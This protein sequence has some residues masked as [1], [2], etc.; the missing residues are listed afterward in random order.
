MSKL[1]WGFIFTVL[2]YS[3]PIAVPCEAAETLMDLSGRWSYAPDADN[4]LNETEAREK[5]R[6]SGT[7][8]MPVPS[9][10]SRQDPAL[11]NYNGVVW[12]GRPFTAK[13]PAGNDRVFL[14][15]GGVDYEADV[16]LNGKPIG[17][18]TGYF[19]TFRLDAT[20]AIRSGENWLTVRV[21][22]PVDQGYPDTKTLVKGIFV[23]HDCRPGS[24][25]GQQ[26]QNEPTGGIWNGVKLVRTG[27][28]TIER[29]MIQAEPAGTKSPVTL[30]YVLRNHSSTRQTIDL[31]L[32][33]RGK[34]FTSEPVTVA[35]HMTIPAGAL[36]TVTLTAVLDDPK[37]WW[38][39]D[40]G[41]P[42]LYRAVSTISIG[43]RSAETRE[44]IFGV[45]KIEF[46]EKTLTMKLNG[47]NLFHKGS[48]YIP[49]QWLS[50]YSPDD[51]RRDIRLMKNANLN[52]IR[53]HA[54]ILPHAFYDAADEAG[55]LVWADFAMIWGYDTGEVF[56][57]EALRQYREFI[58]DWFNHPSIWLWCAHNEG[59][60]NDML[61]I[62]LTELGR[63]IDLTRPQLK[64][65]G[66]WPPGP[67][68]WDEHEYAGWYVGSYLDYASKKHGFVTEYGAQGI[69]R[70]A[71]E[72][73]AAGNRWPPDI[74]DWKY[75]DYQPNENLR[76]LGPLNLYTGVDDYTDASL[77]YQYDLV[78]FATEAYR[79]TKYAPCGGIYHFMF[80]ECWP[81]MTWAVVDHRRD[82]KPAYVALRDA[83]APVIVSLE[84]GKRTVF[85]GDAVEI[86]VWVVS[87][88]TVPLSGWLVRYGV[89]DGQI[90]ESPV[91]MDADAA[92]VVATFRMNIPDSPRDANDKNPNLRVFAELS[93]DNRQVISTSEWE[94]LISTDP[95]QLG[96][97]VFRTGDNMEWAKPDA[98]VSGFKPIR[99]PGNWENDGYDGYDGYG[100][101]RA[102]FRVPAKHKGDLKLSLGPVDDVDELFVNGTFVGRTGTF[103]PNYQTA[104]TDERVYSIP[105][106]ILRRGQINTVALRVYDSIGG[107][108]PYRGP[109]G[110]GERGPDLR[111]R[112]VRDVYP[113]R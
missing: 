77:K 73:L 20:S 22:S 80:T 108:G 65:S 49:T 7:P 15:F 21:H 19:Q 86:P 23:H 89:R 84:V 44:D 27:A 38:T 110:I 56:A 3:Y 52:S 57:R 62:R 17:R 2:L 33:I 8:T 79:R 54:H 105:G 96:N 113:E 63:K 81:A 47:K 12:F 41:R 26:N 71:Q 9:N 5:L 58:E 39:W 87:D 6:Q 111:Y 78:R 25:S 40:R 90:Q 83:M 91:R 75:H 34:T 55:I 104:W 30:N 67:G 13:K 88:R 99:V 66:K 82:P 106:K 14:E 29:V 61:N 68:G 95:Y 109:V 11:L 36:E 37:L 51:F 98:D 50:S 59:S 35:E 43:N 42:D 4:R 46:D 16:F 93:D 101:Y 48:N 32:S 74:D 1:A 69:P 103:P 24:N 64:N 92:A 72:F 97:W 10:W 107:G 53:V 102:S 85:T 100:W 76:A 28:V 18:H 60:A 31:G 112:P 94:F 70:R 45:R